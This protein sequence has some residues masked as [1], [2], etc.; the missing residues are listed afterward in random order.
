MSN[1]RVILSAGNSDKASNQSKSTVHD[2]CLNWNFLLKISR[3][4]IGWKVRK[5]GIFWGYACMADGRAI[6]GGVFV[7]VCSAR[8]QFPNEPSHGLKR[9]LVVY[10]FPSR[11]L[12]YFNF[13]NWFPG[14]SR[15]FSSQSLV[16]LYLRF[17]H[18]QF[19]IWNKWQRQFRMPNQSL[20][21]SYNILHFF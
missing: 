16:F 10:L 6:K 13:L 9:D 2:L 21:T 1:V 5:K 15:C 14:N 19:W 20:I 17:T 8:F 11:F 4:R 18:I 3:E 7:F 12:L